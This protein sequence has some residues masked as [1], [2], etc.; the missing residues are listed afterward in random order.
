MQNTLTRIVQYLKRHRNRD[1]DRSIYILPGRYYLL[2]LPVQTSFAK[3]LDN[4]QERAI[5]SGNSQQVAKIRGD[6]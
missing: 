4:L 1:R 2:R 3:I 6:T 5:A